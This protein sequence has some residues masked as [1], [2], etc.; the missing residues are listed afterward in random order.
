ME[1]PS[2][3]VNQAQKDIESR[4]TRVSKPTYGAK[5]AKEFALG[6]ALVMTAGVE[7]PTEDNKLAADPDEMIYDGEHGVEWGALIHSLLQ[8][9]ME[10]PEADLKQ[11]IKAAQSDYDF[12]AKYGE[13]AE[14]TVRMVMQSDLWLR[15]QRSESRLFE[16]P[17]QVLKEIVTESGDILPTIFR[18]TIDLI[19]KENDGWIL[20]D[21]KTD[22]VKE[23]TFQR[24]VEKY[25]PQLQ[26]YSDA[27]RECTGEPVIE[28]GLFFVQL[29]KYVP[30]ER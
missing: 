7:S 18:G 5:R 6:K 21:Y 25:Y 28:A 3:E 22:I 16:V 20:V 26:I 13:L 1:S 27:W 14:A 9:A 8:L 15:A 30:V 2:E 23:D 11:A 10:N 19:F 24:V 12:T 17:F 29:N 4:I